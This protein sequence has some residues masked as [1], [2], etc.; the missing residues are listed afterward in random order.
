M[1]QPDSSLAAAA[2]R[3]DHEVHIIFVIWTACHEWR[4]GTFSPGYQK[5][6]VC[7][8][9]CLTITTKHAWCSVSELIPLWEEDILSS[10]S[11]VVAILQIQKRDWIIP[12]LRYEGG[13]LYGRQLAAYANTQ[14]LLR[15]CAKNAY[16]IYIYILINTCKFSNLGKLAVH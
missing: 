14:I 1:A 10:R 7:I 15:D 4:P 8:H 2:K 6:C 3:L 11:V 5:M 12:G 16:H 13:Q 9:E